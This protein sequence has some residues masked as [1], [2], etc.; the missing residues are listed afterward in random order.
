MVLKILT[1]S[2][3]IYISLNT[4]YFAECSPRVDLV[5]FDIRPSNF[6]MKVLPAN[7]PDLNLI[8]NPWIDVKRVYLNVSYTNSSASILNR[9]PT[10]RCSTP[11]THF[12]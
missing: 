12:R 4:C 9:Y 10:A 3:L 1:I 8:E 5:Y 11:H 6:H 7:S 2:S